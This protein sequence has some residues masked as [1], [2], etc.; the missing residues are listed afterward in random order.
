MVLITGVVVLY[1]GVVLYLT[2]IF[3]RCGT[4]PK[5]GTLSKCGNYEGVV[6]SMAYTMEGWYLLN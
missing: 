1:Q 5:C 4:L 6:P 2:G 3:L